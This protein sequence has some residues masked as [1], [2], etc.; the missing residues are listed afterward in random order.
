MSDTQQCDELAVIFERAVGLRLRSA[1]EF[2]RA[3]PKLFPTLA[4]IDLAVDPQRHLLLAVARFPGR[5][6]PAELRER[7][8]F[9]ATSL[10]GRPVPLLDLPRSGS[11]LFLSRMQRCPL[12]RVRSSPARLWS[13][14]EEITAALSERPTAAAIASAIARPDDTRP[15]PAVRSPR[16]N[17]TE[18]IRIA[19]DKSADLR[20]DYAGTLS[21]GLIPVRTTTPLPMKAQ[22]TVHLELP[23]GRSVLARGAVVRPGRETTDI[24]VELDEHAH[25]TLECAMNED[26]RPR[27]RALVIDDDALMRRMLTDEL[28]RVGFDVRDAA[29]GWEGLE[30]LFDHLLPVDVLVTDLHMPH[31]D[32]ESLVRL[33]RTG[34][35]EELVVLL[36]TG[37]VSEPLRDQLLAAGATGV[38]DKASG[39]DAI[40]RTADALTRDRLGTFVSTP[41]TRERAALDD[42]RNSTDTA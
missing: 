42:Q 25:A 1:A 28:A 36:V 38:L 5:T 2:L 39:V 29:N 13:A 34:G 3:W 12:V 18:Q 41:L 37:S 40:A 35:E 31:L 27:R 7:F 6:C 23:G 9:W 4:T 10:G 19:Y 26:M 15:R 20:R 17:G 8:A 32:G 24:H 22:V 14:L 21:M 11:A 33:L 16:A 30:L